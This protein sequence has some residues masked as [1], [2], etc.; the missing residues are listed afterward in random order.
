MC[1]PNEFIGGRMARSDAAQLGSLTLVAKT[2]KGKRNDYLFALVSAD[3]QPIFIATCVHGSR[4]GGLTLEGS[5]TKLKADEIRSAISA[6]YNNAVIPEDCVLLIT[7]CHP[8]SI[9]RH[10][11]SALARRKIA[12]V[13]DW[14]STT[15][16]RVTKYKPGNETAEGVWQINCRAD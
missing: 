13:G 2:N 1:T 8:G 4:N 3:E 16:F 12:V 7:P 11:G 14:W 10:R 6:F 5:H 9:W 15:M